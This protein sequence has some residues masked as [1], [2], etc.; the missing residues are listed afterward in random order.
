MFNDRDIDALVAMMTDD[1]E[2]PDVA[3]G[4]VLRD[5][6][7]I[8]SYWEGQFAVSNPQVEPTDFVGVGDDMVAVVKQE[9][10]NLRGEPLVPTTVV[11]HRYSFDGDLVRRMVV[12]NDLDQATSA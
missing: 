3:N 2:W 9:V 12:F 6:A 7:A 8:R 4:A 10:T 1:A 5:K 11:F